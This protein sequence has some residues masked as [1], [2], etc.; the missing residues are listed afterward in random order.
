MSH[1]PPGSG[2]A[3]SNAASGEPEANP[4]AR[5]QVQAYQRLL[6]EYN[7]LDEQ[8]DEMLAAHGGATEKLPAADLE[9]YR[10]LARQ[11]DD[12]HNRL[13]TLERQLLSDDDLS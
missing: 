7:Q 11:R 1:N 9:R 2:S 3:A 12:L 10:Q 5:D 8:I 4:S 6:D 13:R